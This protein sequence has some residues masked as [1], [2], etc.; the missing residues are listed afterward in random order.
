MCSGHLCKNG[1]SCKSL[2][3]LNEL[4]REGREGHD[5][6]EKLWLLPLETPDFVKHDGVWASWLSQPEMVRVKPNLVS[7]WLLTVEY[8]IRINKHFLHLL[9]ILI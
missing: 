8:S 3:G 4:R 6:A 9:S 2:E 7:G 1:E 5:A